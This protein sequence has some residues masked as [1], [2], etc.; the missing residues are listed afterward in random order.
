MF[1]GGEGGW[2]DGVVFL[3]SNG[4]SF[5]CLVG[6]GGCIIRALLCTHAGGGD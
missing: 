2:L 1:G 6:G 3:E 5:V 4:V